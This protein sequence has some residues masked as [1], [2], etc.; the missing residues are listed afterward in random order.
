MTTQTKQDLNF[1]KTMAAYYTTECWLGLIEFGSPKRS[2]LARARAVVNTDRA[3]VLLDDIEL[4]DANT[5][6]RS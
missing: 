2:L 6:A 1:M 5:G 3:L 4:K